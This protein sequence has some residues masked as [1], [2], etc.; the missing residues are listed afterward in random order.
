MAVR[1]LFISR[2]NNARSQMAE[3]LWVRWGEA[4]VR[5]WLETHRREAAPRPNPSAARRQDRAMSRDELVWPGRKAA[6]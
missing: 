3:G 6:P 2:F 1:V 4:R 5:L